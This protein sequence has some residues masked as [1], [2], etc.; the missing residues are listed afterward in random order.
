VWQG[1]GWGKGGE[2]TQTMYAHMNKIK[3]KKIQ[4]FTSAKKRNA[5]I[6]V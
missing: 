1:R 6:A 5:T 2:V 3:I 4:M